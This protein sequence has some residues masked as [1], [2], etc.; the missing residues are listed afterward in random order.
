MPTVYRQIQV[1]WE[2]QW[3]ICALRQETAVVVYKQLSV[4]CDSSPAD[5][6]GRG[7]RGGHVD[8]GKV[9]S[10]AATA[11]DLGT[12][13]STITTR[14]SLADYLEIFLRIHSLLYLTVVTLG[15]LLL[16]Y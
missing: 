10:L 16:E 4:L 1:R 11:A 8:R 12:G 15:C 7:V 3:C 6:H 13:T 2:V 9:T 14:D 5:G